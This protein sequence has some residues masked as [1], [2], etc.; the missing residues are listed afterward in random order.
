MEVAH[1]GT[2]LSISVLLPGGGFHTGSS[3]L[4]MDTAAEG[5]A[6]VARERTER[7]RE[8]EPR[9]WRII[10]IIAGYGLWI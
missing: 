3:F 4:D 6:Q 1:K 7:E 5:G 8:W 9:H 2:S 10:S